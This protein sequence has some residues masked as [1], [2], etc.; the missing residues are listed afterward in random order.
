MLE[1]DRIAPRQRLGRI[2]YGAIFIGIWIFHQD[3]ADPVGP[4]LGPKPAVALPQTFIVAANAG[5]RLI[6]PAAA[7]FQTVGAKDARR[8]L[9]FDNFENFAAKAA[10]AASFTRNWPHA[11]LYPAVR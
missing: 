6:D 9:E 8:L 2:A 5:A 3:H 7:G 10:F 4:K 11:F 1:D